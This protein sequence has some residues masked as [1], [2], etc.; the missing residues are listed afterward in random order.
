MNTE[1]GICMLQRFVQNFIYTYIYIDK[2][3]LPQNTISRLI[4]S[5]A[6][7]NLIL[8]SS[9]PKLLHAVD[10]CLNNSSNLLMTRITL[11]SYSSVSVMICTH[12]MVSEMEIIELK[13]RVSAQAKL[14]KQPCNTQI[15]TVA[16][17]HILHQYQKH[18]CIPCALLVSANKHLHMSLTHAKASKILCNI[19]VYHMHI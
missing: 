2:S 14:V 10:N 11:P 17:V 5:A 13:A 4:L 19:E 6:V 15:S 16:A 7:S 8:S 1:F 18:T 9:L 12:S 3:Y